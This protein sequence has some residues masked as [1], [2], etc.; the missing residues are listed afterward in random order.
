MSNYYPQ[1]ERRCLL[2][3][4]IQQYASTEKYILI[5]ASDLLLSQIYLSGTP[6]GVAKGEDT[7]EMNWLA[8]TQ[9]TKELLHKAMYAVNL[10]V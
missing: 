9:N 3:G 10:R 6:R 1:Y 7:L 5:L 8:E 4:G 2:D